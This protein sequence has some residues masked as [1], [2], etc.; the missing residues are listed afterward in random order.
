VTA[1]TF[2]ILCAR[3]GIAP[4]I[5]LENAR[6]RAALAR[7]DDAAVVRILETEF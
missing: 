4:C 2:A 6:I 7:R 1:S 5:A 3:Y